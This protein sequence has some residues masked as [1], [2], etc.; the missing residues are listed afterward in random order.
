MFPGYNL[1]EDPRVL[2]QCA[3]YIICSVIFHFFFKQLIRI[4]TCINT[5]CWVLSLLHCLLFKR[6]ELVN[7]WPRK[8]F[9]SCCWKYQVFFFFSKTKCLF[10]QLQH[11]PKSSLFTKQLCVKVNRPPTYETIRGKILHS[12]IAHFC[13]WLI[14][15]FGIFKLKYCF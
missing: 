4:I 1:S 15:E 2:K 14:A 10:Q 11:S 3:I 7:T 6:T 12:V 8:L 5:V 9:E 13:H